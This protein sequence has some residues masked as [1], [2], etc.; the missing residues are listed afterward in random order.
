MTQKYVLKPDFSKVEALLLPEPTDAENSPDA[1]TPIEQRG[2]KLE[3]I[4][5]FMRAIED[6][7]VDLWKR[8][9]SH[10]R[11][12]EHLNWSGHIPE[13]ERPAY[14]R[15]PALNGY[16]LQGTII[17]PMTQ[18]CQLS[19]YSRIPP[20]VRGEPSVF[21]S[22]AWADPLVR[23]PGTTLIDMVSGNN[24][25]S[26]NAFCWLDLFVYNQHTPQD[27]AQDMERIIGTVGQLVMP[28][29]SETGLPRLWCIW[30]WLAAHRAWATITLP[31]AA[32][33]RYYFGKKRDWFQTAFTTIADAQTTHP[34]DAAQIMEEILRTFGSVEAADKEIRALAD[35]FFTHADQA[36]WHK[37]AKE[38]N[39]KP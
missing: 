28:M 12:Y 25:V 33:S 30:E 32:Y 37:A 1:Q 16:F 23:T 15:H 5:E 38:K 7:F 35:K 20:E 29:S 6:V 3:W 10:E 9:E 11:A 39:A 22:H 26:D 4:F 24:R 14:E 21:V 2:V 13:A 36:P 17:K 19:L 27:I 34:E 8:Y 31:E 18:N